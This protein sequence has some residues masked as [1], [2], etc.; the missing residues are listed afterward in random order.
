MTMSKLAEVLTARNRHALNA[1]EAAGERVQGVLGHAHP[2]QGLREELTAIELLE[3]ERDALDFALE[4]LRR[5]IDDIAVPAFL[6]RRLLEHI[7][8]GAGLEQIRGFTSV[9][10]ATQFV[11]DD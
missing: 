3:G 9:L 11:L 6:N 8:D 2:S 4:L 10:T 1:M 5:D 7:T